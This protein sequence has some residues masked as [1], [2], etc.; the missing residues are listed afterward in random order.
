VTGLL[1]LEFRDYGQRKRVALGHRDLTAAKQK[2]DELAAALRS[3]DS[4]LQRSL[5]LTQLFDNYLREVTPAKG[6]HKQDHDRRAARMILS[7]LGPGRTVSSLTIRDWQHFTAERRRRGDQRQGK[8]YG[9]ALGSRMIRYDLQFLLATCNWAV[10]AGWLE[11]NPLEGCPFPK[12]DVPCRPLVTNDQYNRLLGVSDRVSP[13]CRLALVLAHETGHRIGAIRLLRWSDVRWAD[14]VIRWR[15]GHDK[16]RF[17]HETPMTP[18]AREALAGEQRRSG[19]I[20]DAWVFLSP[21]NGENPVSRHLLRDWWQ[22]LEQFADLE[23]ETRRGW[24][25]LRRKFATELKDVP[26]VDLCAL[27]GWK[28]PQTVLRCYQRA[29]PETMRTALA[30]RRELSA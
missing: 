15:G 3:P 9:R 13:L 24:H 29:D 6:E 28:E 2:A 7:I 22:R 20:G 16:I 25:A 17:E 12:E 26:L 11:R 23:P 21:T 27:G 10:R 18:T 30:R 4:S 14:G 1:F 19:V 5:L 8:T